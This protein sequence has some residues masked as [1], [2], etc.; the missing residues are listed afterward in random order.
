MERLCYSAGKWT[1]DGEI[2]DVRSPGGEIVGRAIRPSGAVVRETLERTAAVSGELRRMPVY[3]RADILARASAI[4]ASR[5]EVFARLI[6]AESGKPV[7]YS[8]GE[9][10][11]AVNT[12]SEASQECSRVYG[13][14][15]PLDVSPAAEGRV[16]MTS[17]FP[18]GPVLAITPFNFPLNLVAHKV[19][20]AFAAGCP[21]I[22]KPS[23][24]T[25]LTAL[26]L[27]EVLEEAGFP[28]GALSVLPLPGEEA[29]KLARA[30][31]I[32]MI[33]FT[34]SAATGWKL[35]RTAWNKKVTLELG[36]NA[37]VG[38][39]PDWEDL[40]GAAARITTGGYAFSGQVCISVQRILVSASIMDDFMGHYL[41]RVKSL[42][43]GDLADERTDIGPMITENEAIRVES[44]VNEALAGGASLA[45]GGNRDG[46]F[47]EPTV[48]TGTTRGMKVVSEEVFGPVTV[49]SGYEGFDDLI[50]AVN[51]SRFG[52][53]AGL[54]SRDMGRIRKAFSS[55]EVGGVII[56]DVPTFRVDR[57]PY[58][59]VKESGEGREGLRYAIR[60]MSERRLLV[61]P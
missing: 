25:P 57:M 36:G 58:G 40:A 23:S 12:F 1:D 28:P 16:G 10:D 33:S 49:V 37:A 47:Y 45:A 54:F 41:G 43:R 15:I 19:A 20:P 22:V 53:Q 2:F 18:V 60:E 26:L 5:R 38:I 3:R 32:R 13:E 50:E 29:E 34:G 52:L 9:A 21:V 61:L 55:L 46:S 59:G 24:E 35:K 42:K 27:A 8:R 56:G 39:E 51:D 6:T 48:L 7:R 17:F 4:I 44:W 31:E 11:R 30:E 14:L